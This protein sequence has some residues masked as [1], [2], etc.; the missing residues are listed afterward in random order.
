[1]PE[2]QKVPAPPYVAYKTFRN[3]LERFKQGVPGRIDRGVMVGMSGAA[4]SQIKTALRY[5]N[6]I[7][8][9]DLPSDL[10]KQL[11][12]SDGDMRKS[13]LTTIIKSAYPYIFNS[14]T[15]NFSSA[16]GSQLR[17]QIETTTTA[18]GETV[19]R[20][21]SFLRDIAVD[22]GLQVSPYLNQK[23]QKNGGA[24]RKSKSPLAKIKEEKIVDPVREVHHHT[25]ASHPTAPAQ[26]SLLLW[27]L[28]Q[29]LP[30]PGSVWPKTEREQWTVTLNNVLAMEYKD[31]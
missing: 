30:K 27:G 3:F 9:H 5:L 12:S 21:L 15:I 2:E 11:C 6:L 7:S 18:S 1:M 22:A 31:Q 4:Q 19:D 17:E 29:R 25:P 16:T 13:T 10:M 8:E 24:G 20:C 28:F 23:R 26:D 14:P